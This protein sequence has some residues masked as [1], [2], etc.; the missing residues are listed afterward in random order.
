[1]KI[2]RHLHKSPDW[3]YEVSGPG[4]DSKV[5]PTEGCA[6]A[7]AQGFACHLERPGTFYVREHGDVLWHIERDESGLVTTRAA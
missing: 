2:K 6:I 4:I 1:M 7:T 3:A 5:A